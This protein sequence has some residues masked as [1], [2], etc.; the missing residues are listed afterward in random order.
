[1]GTFPP[2]ICMSRG[3]GGVSQFGFCDTENTRCLGGYI[4]LK[5]RKAMPSKWAVTDLWVCRVKPQL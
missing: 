5:L 1:M 3:W 2:A 4:H